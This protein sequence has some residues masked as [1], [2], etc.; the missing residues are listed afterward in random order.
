MLLPANA[1]RHA[2]PVI[3][4]NYAAPKMRLQRM[5]DLNVS[6]VLDHSEFRKYL[7]ASGHLDVRIDANMKAPFSIDKTGNPLCFEFH[8][9]VSQTLSL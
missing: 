7:E 8:E 5:E 4:A 1:V 6:L 9:I 2:V 3:H